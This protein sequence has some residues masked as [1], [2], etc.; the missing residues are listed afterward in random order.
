MEHEPLD[1][2][3]NYRPNQSKFSFTRTGESAMSSI[4]IIL[5]KATPDRT[6]E[7]AAEGAS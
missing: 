6:G 7:Q 1:V 2:T 5:G 3:S 4:G